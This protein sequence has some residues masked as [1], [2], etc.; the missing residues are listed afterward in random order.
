[1]PAHATFVGVL[2]QATPSVPFAMDL[3]S[4]FVLIGL[5]QLLAARGAV[6]CR[7]FVRLSDRLWR[8]VRFRQSLAWV[9]QLRVLDDWHAFGGLA[10]V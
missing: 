9:G 3:V 7:A 1:M 4:A 6:L 5:T 8:F 2:C 10:T